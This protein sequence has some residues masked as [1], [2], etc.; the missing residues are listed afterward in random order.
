[1]H[2]SAILSGQESLY[3]DIWDTVDG[4]ER[5][6]IQLNLRSVSIGNGWF[7]TP[8]QIR[9][10]IGFACGEAKAEGVPTL[11]SEN[12]CK[13]S[14]DEWNKCEKLLESCEDL[15]RPAYEWYLHFFSI[16][17]TLTPF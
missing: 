1:M 14:W 16:R 3:E 17:I 10:L 11:L 8:A 5:D 4:A 6:E 13:W 15:T 9:S 7:A 12:E 2:R